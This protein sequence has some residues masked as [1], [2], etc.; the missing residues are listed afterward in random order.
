MKKYLIRISGLADLE[1]NVPVLKGRKS[2]VLS[3]IILSLG[4]VAFLSFLLIIPFSNLFIG[5]TFE[6][7]SFEA[8]IFFMCLSLGLL[9]AYVLLQGKK[10]LTDPKYFL[11]VLF[12]AL[13]TTAASVL[14]SPAHISNTFGEVVLRSLSG[15]TIMAIVGFF[16]FFSLVIKDSKMLKRASSL[17]SLSLAILVT[18]LV[19]H[20]NV[21]DT[22]FVN[23]NLPIVLFAYFY[24]TLGLFFSKSKR[25]LKAILLAVSAI[26]VF[27]TPQTIPNSILSTQVITTGLL[28]LFILGVIYS[29]IKKEYVKARLA[30]LTVIKTSF[31]DKRYSLSE[32]SYFLL[33]VVSLLAIVTGVLIHFKFNF[34]ID[35]LVN[36][37]NSFINAFKAP[38]EGTLNAGKFILGNGS[39]DAARRA[40]NLDTS[41]SSVVNVFV[42]QGLVGILA[43]LFIVVTGFIA[44]FKSIKRSILLRSHRGLVFLSAF[45]LLFV[46][47]FSLIT[48]SGELLIIFWWM[49]FAF[50][51][52]FLNLKDLR[53]IYIQNDWT[54]KSLI[55]KNKWGIYLRVLLSL[56]IIVLSVAALLSFSRITI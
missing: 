28:T 1:F 19:F 35:I 26:F 21:T 25:I 2:E 52:V 12:F 30:K 20:V 33:L 9:G 53:S 27:L 43:Y 4:V 22:N 13:L 38:L 39:Y 5:K 54:V 16:Y 10:V 23:N 46:S 37:L 56:L 15:I 40:S 18:L 34:T 51:S 11:S 49:A 8:L 14:K 17:F 47:I 3:K 7:S 32:V 36:P 55:L 50:F 44:M 24:L 42:T 31:K 29:I 6:E 48:Y 41:V 45:S